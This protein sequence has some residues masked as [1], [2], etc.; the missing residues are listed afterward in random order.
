MRT[1]PNPDDGRCSPGSGLA[2]SA[3]SLRGRYV[4]PDLSVGRAG[5]DDPL[6]AHSWR[7]LRD[8]IYEQHK[9]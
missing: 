8:I 1:N 2:S 7:D 5:D 4:L 3:A 6:E 9:T